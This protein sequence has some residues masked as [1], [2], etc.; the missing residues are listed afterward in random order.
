[1][2]HCEGLGA[3]RRVHEKD[4]HKAP[5]NAE[6]TRI[7]NLDGPLQHEVMHRMR[8]VAFVR[9]LGS[10]LRVLCFPAF[11]VPVP[12]VIALCLVFCLLPLFL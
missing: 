2:E 11:A 1:M 5:A 3:Y 10:R 6:L 8:T 7:C 9:N 12:L 4:K